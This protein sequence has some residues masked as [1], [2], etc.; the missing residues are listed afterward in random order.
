[1][2]QRSFQRPTVIYV[3][4]D[5]LEYTG[6][7]YTK[8]CHTYQACHN[9]ER[10]IMILDVYC[11]PND[12]SNVFSDSIVWSRSHDTWEHYFTSWKYAKALMNFCTSFLTIGNQNCD[13]ILNKFRCLWMCP[14]RGDTWHTDIST[15]MN[16]TSTT[17]RLIWITLI[18]YRVS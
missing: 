9:I 16:L 15:H 13:T 1:M 7:S 2:K 3:I 4:C 6:Y 18:I 5:L 12:K 17:N 14:A 11:I 8:N 10:S